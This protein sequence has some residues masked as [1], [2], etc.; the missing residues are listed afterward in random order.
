MKLQKLEI[1]T[2]MITQLKSNDIYSYLY[3]PKFTMSITLNGQLF[4]LKLIEQLT[5]QLSYI[6]VLQANTDGITLIIK[7]TDHNQLLD[8]CKWWEE[9]S[10]LK[11]EYAYYQ[12][13]IIRDVNSYYA[14]YTDPTKDIK[15]KGFFE[16]DKAWHK[17]HSMLI[18]MKALYEYFINNISVEYTIYSSTN[19]FD[20]C[21]RGR[22][23]SDSYLISRHYDN[24]NVVDTKLQKNIRY[25]IANTGIDLIKILPP[26]DNKDKLEKYRREN[27]L[28]LDLFHFLDDVKIEKDRESYLEANYKSK[29]FNRFYSKPY[30]NDYDINYDYYINECYKIIN[31]IEKN[32]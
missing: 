2:L 23:N 28:Q 25:Y 29:L 14:I 32:E 9:F 10:N 8:I 20:F 5:I 30:F 27:P 12:K 24:G 18:V 26:L 11:L 17:N 13:M 15:V 16:I 3:D 4:I 19:I 1:N 6:K 22:S 7:R 21:K 31:I